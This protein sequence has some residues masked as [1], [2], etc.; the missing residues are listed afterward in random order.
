MV[1]FIGVHNDPIIQ[2]D[3]LILRGLSCLALEGAGPKSWL[4][5]LKA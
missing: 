1:L 4:R 3:Y 5:R 2:A